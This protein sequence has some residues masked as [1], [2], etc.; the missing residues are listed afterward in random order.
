MKPLLKTV[1]S[2]AEPQPMPKV[3]IWVNDLF[4]MELYR[5]AFENH[6]YEWNWEI[7]PQ[8][9]KLL[10]KR[11]KPTFLILDLSLFSKNPIEAIQELKSLSPLTAIIVLSHTE[12]VH[13]AISAFKAGISDYY[14]KPTNPETLLYA[15]QKF[16]S[17]KALLPPDPIM[18]ADLEMFGVTHHISIAESASKMRELAINH[19]LSSLDARGAI[20]LCP[21]N[22]RSENSTSLC[23]T[24]DGSNFAFE[25]WGCQSSQEALSELSEF[26][27]NNP[28][29][30]RDSF[31]THLT[32]HPEHWFRKDTAWIP[33][34]NSAMG[35]ILLFGLA[36]KVTSTLITRAEFLIRSLEISLENQQRYIEARQLSYIDDLTGLYN[37][38]FLEQALSIAMD[39]LKRSG[40]G[41]C[42]LFIDVDKFKQVNDQH[43]HLIGSQMLTH[44]GRL[45]KNS[46]R[47]IDHLFRYGGDE[48][49][50]VLYDTEIE[51]AQEIAER[52]RK[53]V[54]DRIFKFPQASLKVTLSIGIARFPDHGK[55]KES[56]ISMADRAMYLSKKQGRNQVIVALPEDH[57]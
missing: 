47:K 18:Q 33:L 24:L 34:K 46:F 21:V 23:H 51:K 26:Q 12:D 56:V 8:N 3:D 44:I 17:Q 25:H 20:W 5:P 39:S 13:V 19:L 27:K 1:H 9:W 4:L 16:F 40:E 6:P 7:A 50:A 30:I 42:V 57:A 35:G 14:L 43:G 15:V 11:N 31:F 22:N 49:I 54:E 2:K 28:L 55:S 29:L 52:I 41:F 36:R 37:S 53:T 48:F 45:L 10:L 32:S 38:R